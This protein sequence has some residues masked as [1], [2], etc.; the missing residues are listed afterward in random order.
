[1]N[2]FTKIMLIFA[3]IMLTPFYILIYIA[4]LVKQRKEERLKHGL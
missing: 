2:R 4:Y 3:D 1:M